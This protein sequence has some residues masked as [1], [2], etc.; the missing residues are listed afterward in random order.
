MSQP[1]SYN[2]GL[3]K[4]RAFF[5]RAEEVASTDNFDYAIDLYLEGLRLFPDALED[6][7]APLRRLAL[8]RQGKGGKKPSMMEKMKHM[9]G[10]TPLEEMLNAE[11][12]LAKDS[13]HLPYAEDMLKAAVAGG[14]L[15]TAEWLALLIFDANHSSDKPS[16]ATYIMLK[17]A[18]IKMQMFTKA[19]A[20][21]QHA[22][23]IKP[24]D[25]VL[26]DELR[27]LCASMTM[28][29]GRYGKTDDFRDSIQDRDSQEMLQHQDSIIKTV[30]YK[31]Q[32]IQQ[33]RKKI[34]D[35]YATTTN[36]LELADALFALESNESEAEA[37]TLLQNAHEKSKDFTFLKRVG[38]FRIKKLKNQI[39]QIGGQLRQNPDD[40]VL[41]KQ[42]QQVQHQL[43]EVELEHFK[44]CQQNYPTD[45]RLKFEYGRCLLKAQQF[46]AA[47]PIFQESQKDPR[48][49]L[50]SMDKIGLCFLLKGWM[51]DAID[52]FRAAL[53]HCVNKE[54]TIAKDIRYNLARAYESSGENVKALEIYR[55][56]AQTD[57]SYKDVGQRIDN[58]RKDG[59]R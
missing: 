55:K 2:A 27:D 57:F 7:H 23:E 10:K 49:K 37:M 24:D 5:E 40:T 38:E 58:L 1:D 56:L 33:A 16:F 8:M 51:E 35:G 3:D 42:I 9:R 39:R 46:D 53:E 25:S 22:I 31:K 13:D 15:R 52:I 43:D 41:Q 26:R 44:K 4:A 21:C 12:L 18:Y 6:G 54:G 59:K 34:Q 47:I 17:D 32:A 30:D 29:K 36:I 48:L 14:Y 28:E 50:A 45:L 11:F 19:V 20:A